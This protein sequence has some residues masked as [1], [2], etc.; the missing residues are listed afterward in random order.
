[1]LLL[2]NGYREEYLKSKAVYIH[3]ITWIGA[4]VIFIPLLAGRFEPSDAPYAMLGS[5]P[6]ILFMSFK[7]F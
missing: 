7:L 1:M 2:T 5:S 3:A 4:M 6:A